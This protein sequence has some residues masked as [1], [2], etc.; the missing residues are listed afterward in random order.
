MSSTIALTV[1]GPDDNVVL[2]GSFAVGMTADPGPRGAQPGGL[3]ACH[4][5]LGPVGWVSAGGQSGQVSVD[6]VKR[7]LR[8][9]RND[10]H[11]VI[12]ELLDGSATG[13]K[14]GVRVGGRSQFDEHTI[15]T[16]VYPDIA[17]AAGTCESGRQQFPAE[18][19][20]DGL[21]LVNEQPQVDSERVDTAVAKHRPHRRN[22]L[23][24][25][26]EHRGD[27]LV[28]AGDGRRRSVVG[29]G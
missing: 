18:D 22:V 1:V 12:H 25:D 24:G 10:G 15:S 29:V 23:A 20:G 8:S 4:A 13:E 28:I 19:P 2:C 14:D 27:Q 5:G 3:T 16:G 7:D 11:G 21:A 6:I 9:A 17:D 26:Q